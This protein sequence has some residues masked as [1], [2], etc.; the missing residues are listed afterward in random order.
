MNHLRGE[1][2]YQICSKLELNKI[3]I[4]TKINIHNI[5]LFKNNILSMCKI[6]CSYYYYYYYYYLIAH[7]CWLYIFFA[8]ANTCPLWTSWSPSR[9]WP[10]CNR[11]LRLGRPWGQLHFPMRW[12]VIYEY[13]IPVGILNLSSTKLPRP[14]SPWE[15]SPSRKNHHD[16]TGNRPRDLMISSQKL[17]PL[18][19]E[20]GHFSRIFRTIFVTTPV[21][22]T[23]S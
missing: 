14:W 18:D 7:L 4:Y 19:H 8:N 3:I 17:W 22:S 11:L 2:I 10:K 20:A 23:L 15:T 12:M 9:L 13:E 5:L 1:N 16:R 6:G 21:N